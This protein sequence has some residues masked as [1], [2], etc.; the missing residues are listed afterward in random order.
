MSTLVAVLAALRPRQWVKNF[1]VFAGLI[2]SQSLFTPLVWPALAAFVIFCALSGAIY[3]F[4]DVAD[5]EKDRLHPTK[6]YRPI[7]RGALSL[8]AALVL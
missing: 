5:V 4:N 3:V 8:P 1:F 7:A 6:R 2:F